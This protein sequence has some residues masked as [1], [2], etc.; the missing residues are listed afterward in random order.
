EVVADVESRLGRIDRVVHCAAIMPASE[1]LDD[2]LA[3]MNKVM[4]INYG[5]TLNMI[6]ATL[7]PMVERGHGAFVVVGSVAG[8]ALT[9]HLGPYCASKAAVNALMEIL[10]QEN[11]TSGVKIHLVCPPMVNTPLIKQAQKTSN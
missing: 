1:V 4:A 8:Y 2:D 10:I 6:K 7:E 5:G 11:R 9:P 3:R